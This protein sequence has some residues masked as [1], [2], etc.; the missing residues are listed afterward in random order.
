[1]PQPGGI[2]PT[3]GTT[4]PQSPGHKGK[5]SISHVWHH[6]GNRMAKIITLRVNGL[7]RLSVKFHG[8]EVHSLSPPATP[9]TAPEILAARSLF[10]RKDSCSPSATAACV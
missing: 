6:F 8:K 10:A 3:C 9:V 1:M 2:V 4:K 7:D 5:P